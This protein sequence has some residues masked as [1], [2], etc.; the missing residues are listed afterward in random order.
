MTLCEKGIHLP[1]NDLNVLA[2]FS[3][4]QDKDVVI[5]QALDKGYV[6]SWQSCENK[7]SQLVKM[8]LLEKT[9]LKKRKISSKIYKENNSEFMATTLK[10]HNIQIN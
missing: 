10:V 9:D 6:R 5:Q 2:L 4:N 8:D 1:E 3:M 7:V